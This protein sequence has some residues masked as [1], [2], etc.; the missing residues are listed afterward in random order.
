MMWMYEWPGRSV[1]GL[2]GLDAAAEVLG[3]WD[4]ARAM[5]N[6]RRMRVEGRMVFAGMCFVCGE[7]PVRARW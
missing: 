2:A 5:P 3:A 6:A 4:M 1:G 7:V